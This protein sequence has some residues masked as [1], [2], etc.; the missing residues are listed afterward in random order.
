MLPCRGQEAPQSA[1]PGVFRMAAA[2]S[3]QPVVPLGQPAMDAPSPIRRLPWDKIVVLL[4]IAAI[5]A[6]ITGF[7]VGIIVRFWTAV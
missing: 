3:T 6:W 4:A 5:C 1:L 2:L 7:M